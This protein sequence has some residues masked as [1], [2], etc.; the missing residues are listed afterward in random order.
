M[1]QDTLKRWSAGTAH[2]PWPGEPDGWRDEQVDRTTVKRTNGFL[3]GWHATSDADAAALMRAAELND[4]GHRLFEPKPRYMNAEWYQA[5]PRI[6]NMEIEYVAGVDTIRLEPDDPGREL[7]AEPNQRVD[8]ITVVAAVEHR[9]RAETIRWDTDLAF[10]NEEKGRH[11]DKCGLRMTKTT[12]MTRSSLEAILRLAMFH[13]INDEGT[14]GFEA[15]NFDFRQKAHYAACRM[16]LDPLDA[17]TEIVRNAVDLH[18]AHLVPAGHGLEIRRPA[19]TP[20][21][22]VKFQTP[23]A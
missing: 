4:A 23:A 13:P 21:I 19:G 14:E 11:P 6:V 2:S 22:D 5:L 16:L 3:V 9:D 10:K 1:R 12:G 7:K 17:A 20:E 15:E 18:V 8:K